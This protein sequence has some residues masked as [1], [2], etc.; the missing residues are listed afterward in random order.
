MMLLL[1]AAAVPACATCHAAKA[2]SHNSTNMARALTSAADVV[3]PDSSFSLGGK[4]LLPA[5]AGV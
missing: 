4:R 3:L 1:L 2:R 5:P